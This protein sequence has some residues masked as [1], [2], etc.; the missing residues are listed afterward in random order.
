GEI[1]L[2]LE[3]LPLEFLWVE[4]SKCGKTIKMN[5]K[6]QT[7]HKLTIIPNKDAISGRLLPITARILLQ[8]PQA[9]FCLVFSLGILLCA[10]QLLQ[11]IIFAVTFYIPKS[12]R[13]FHRF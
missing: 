4:F 8:S 12:S 1:F 11:S 7:N 5:T 2:M 9:A 13:L 10:P 6:T 3:V